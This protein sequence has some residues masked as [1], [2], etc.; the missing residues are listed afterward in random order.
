M[1][2]LPADLK[3]AATH[4]WARMEDDR[5]V[6][7]GITD[8]AQQELGDLVFIDLPEPGKKL[9]SKEQCATLESV[10]TASDLYSP[11]AGEVVEVNHEAADNPQLVNED[12][13]GTWLFSLRLS[14]PTELD[15]LLTADDYRRTIEE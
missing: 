3:Y 8:F 5:L 11:V 9:N 7:V 13:Y 4:E 2:N 15:R 14:E 6:R 12:P 1:T 10:K